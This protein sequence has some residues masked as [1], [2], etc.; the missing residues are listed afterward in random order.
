M[1]YRLDL[2]THSIASP[3]GGLRLRDYATMLGSGVLDSVAITDHN[4]VDFALEAQAKLGDAVIVGEEIKTTEG[5]L[6]GLY[7]TD[8]VPSGLSALETAERIHAQGGLVYVPHPFETVR[9]G[10]ADAA[11]YK[12]AK[13]VDIMEVYNGRALFQNRSALSENWA[14][15]HGCVGA[16]SSDAH[17]SIGWGKTYTEIGAAPTRKTLVHE[18]Q[19]AR[20]NKELVGIIGALYPKYNRLRKMV[21]VHV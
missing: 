6:I 8:A 16:A 4:R 18:L 17:G 10:M 15:E 13:Q 19:H 14:R 20:Y 5:E 9:S 21:G 1:I 2:H 12:I 7:L 11:L 3:D